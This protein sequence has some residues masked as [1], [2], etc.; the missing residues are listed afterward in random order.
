[1]Q[2]V[3]ERVTGRSTHHEPRRDAGLLGGTQDHRQPQHHG[4]RSATAHAGLRPAVGT[5]DGEGEL[6]KSRVAS[7]AGTRSASSSAAAAWPRCTSGTTPGSAAP[8]PIKML[9]SDLARDPSSRPGSAARPSPRP[10]STTRRSSRSTTPARTRTSSGGHVDARTSSWST[11][12]GATLRELLHAGRQLLPER[13][14]RDHRRHPRRAGVQPPHGHR[15]PRHQAGQ[16]HADPHRRQVK[17][18]DFG[19]ARAM[20]DSAATMTQTAVGHRHRAVPLARAGQGREGRRPHRPLLHRLPALRAAHRPAAVHRR[21][22]GRRRLPARPRE[23]Q[24]RRR[25]ST[26]IGRRPRRRRPAGARQGPRGALPGRRRDAA[27]TSTGSA[28]RS[29]RAEPSRRAPPSVRRGQP[30]TASGVVCRR[31]HS[32]RGAAGAMPRRSRRRDEQRGTWLATALI[33]VL[34]LARARPHRLGR[35]PPGSAADRRGRQRPGATHH[36][37]G[38]GDRSAARA[39]STSRAEIERGSATAPE[40]DVISQDPAAGDAGRPRASRPLIVSRGPDKGTVPDVTGLQPERGADRPRRTPGSRS[41]SSTSNSPD[42]PKDKV[43]NDRPASDPQV[44]TGDSASVSTRQ[45]AR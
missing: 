23:P 20:A 4:V 39:P 5:D 9:R 40:G 8:S 42:Q 45:P 35:P 44:G 24:P 16:R 3:L 36:R 29:A 14:A 38:R 27:S 13:G 1:M 25:R 22:P 11:S 43:T 2:A 28:G 15:P 21:L 37:H 12:T 30:Q 18:M 34:A 31:R 19:I 17:V 41:T 6:W 26:R 7:A 10:R 32:D 33:A